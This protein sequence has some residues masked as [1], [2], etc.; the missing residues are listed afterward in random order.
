MISIDKSGSPSQAE[1]LEALVVI[2]ALVSFDG[3]RSKAR[4]CEPFYNL[5]VMLVLFRWCI[6]KIRPRHGKRDEQTTYDELILADLS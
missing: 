1:P 4:R 3:K 5:L 2:S 6:T